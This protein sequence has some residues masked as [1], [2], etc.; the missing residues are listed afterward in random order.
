M[1]SQPIS[2]AQ[3]KPSLQKLCSFFMMSRPSNVMMIRAHSGV[4]GTHTSC[5]LRAK[6][7]ALLVSDFICEQ[8]GYLALT[9]EEYETAKLTDTTIRM[10]ARE[11]LEYGEA[12]EGYWTAEKFMKQLKVAVQI[13]EVKYPASEGWKHVWLFDHS[14]CHAA[15][16]DDALDVTKMNVNPGGKQHRMRDGWWGG[17]PQAMNFAIDVPKGLRAVLE[18]RGVNT[19]KMNA[20]QMRAILGSHPDFKSQKSQVEDF[21]QQKG[22]VAVLLPKYHYELNPIERV[23]AQ[24]KWFSRAHCKYT[25]QSLRTVINPALDSVTL[26][27]TCNHF[28]KVRHYMFAYL[29]GLPG[30]SDLEK[31]VKNTKLK[32]SLTIGSHQCS[33]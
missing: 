14:S 6:G 11:F 2:N 12:R 32:L 29:E 1:L 5:V 24:A 33:N 28:R 16:A 19:K 26:E 15:M 4:P 27:N 17:K 31:L 22:H 18:E 13:A 21:L 8:H 3:M 23:W 20:D 30:G 9:S 10:Q 25:L 7:L